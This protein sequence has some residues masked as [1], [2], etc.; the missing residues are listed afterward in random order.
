MSDN[1]KLK[2][3]YFESCSC[4]TAVCPCIFLQSP[5]EGYCKAL[6]GWV[7][8]EGHMDSTDLS[9]LNVGLYLNAPGD[10]TEGGWQVALYL[11]DRAS[12]EQKAALQK[13]YGGEVGGHP[14][15]IASLFGKVMGVHS[16]SIKIDYGDKEKS[17]VIEG[18]GET[19]V[20]A[21]EGAEGNDVTVCNP[22]LAVAPGHDIH[23]HQTKMMKYDHEEQ[24]SHEGTTSLASA[25][26]YQP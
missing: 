21:L 4:D 14:A 2:G 12:D 23:V 20:H 8:D 15:V 22:P 17:L 9:G 6:I 25:F 13:I 24:H 19:R 18:V 3:R 7:I 1:W 26:T 10:L 16:A 11:D 5:T